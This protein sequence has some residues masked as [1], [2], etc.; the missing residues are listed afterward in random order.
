[1]ENLLVQILAHYPRLAPFAT[2]ND[3][4][5]SVFVSFP[6]VLAGIPVATIPTLNPRYKHPGVTHFHFSVRERKRMTHIV[7]SLTRANL[8]WRFS[9]S[10]NSCKVILVNPVIFIRC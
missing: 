2:K 7:E 3:G 6:H 5:L 4:P 10:L 9:T 1:V 8:M